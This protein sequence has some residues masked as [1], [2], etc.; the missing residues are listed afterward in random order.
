[1]DCRS[2]RCGRARSS[3]D[4]VKLSLKRGFQEIELDLE[5]G[6]RPEGIDEN[7]RAQAFSEWMDQ[8]KI[9]RGMIKPKAEGD[10]SA[11]QPSPGNSP[12]LPGPVS[13]VIPG[14][15]PDKQK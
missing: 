8:Q 7:R 1:M 3:G 13:P 12:R 5:L 4:N 6:P 9:A 15:A 11:Q 2:D 14:Q 10:G